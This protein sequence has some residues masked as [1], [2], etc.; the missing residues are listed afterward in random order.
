MDYEDEST[1]ALLADAKCDVKKDPFRGDRVGVRG[2]MA[3]RNLV[4]WKIQTG[5]SPVPTYADF[6]FL[7]TE[8]G[9]PYRVASVC[10]CTL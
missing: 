7:S 6:L 3:Y 8:I 2:I 4:A 9:V 10:W 1:A 5:M